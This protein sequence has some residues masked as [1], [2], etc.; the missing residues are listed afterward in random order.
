RGRRLFRL[1]PA[2]QPDRFRRLR[3]VPA[4]RQP[5]D[6]DRGGRAPHDRIGRGAAGPAAALVRLP[7][8]AAFHRVLE[9]RAISPARPRAL[10]PP[11]ARRALVRAAALPL[12]GALS[13]NK[14]KTFP[15]IV[16]VEPG[17]LGLR[18]HL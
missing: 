18:A 2:R 12:S 14:R 15:P 11:G 16:L 1:A 3:A 5:R 8:R 13:S 4:P 7:P 10:Y 17:D 6:A 9:G